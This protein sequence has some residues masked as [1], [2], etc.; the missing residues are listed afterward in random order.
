M[1]LSKLF[2]PASIAVVGAS[3]EDGKV[4]AVI[5]KNLLTL[6]FAGEVFLVNPKHKM[7]FGQ[8]CYASLSDIGTSVDLAVLAI[9][10]KFVNDE[11]AKNATRIKNYVV[12]SAGFAE[13]GP[14]GKAR[15][16]ALAQIAT[17]N[18]LNILGPNCLGFIVPGMK[19][20]A[21]FAG[22]MP[23]DGNVSFVSQSGALAVALMDIAEKENIG[24]SNI[25]SVGNKMQL[26]ETELLEYL[27]K[28][29]N[30]KV[31]G[32]Y[33][34]SV[35]DGKRFKEVSQAV[36][37]RKPVIIL[38]A[39]KNAKTQK[40]ISSH[41]GALAGDDE[42][43]SAVFRKNGVMR[44]NNLEEFFNLFNL[45]RNCAAPEKKGVAVITN[46]GGVG[47]LAADAFS[48]NKIMLADISENIKNELRGFLPAESSVENPIDLL[49]DAQDDRYSKALKAVSKIEDVGSIICVLTPQDQTPAEKIAEAIIDFKKQDKKIIV[50]VFLGGIRVEAA[51]A[52]LKENGICNFSFPDQ[53]VQSLDRYFSWNEFRKRKIKASGQIINVKR[54]EKV[55]AVIGK[56]GREGRTALYFSESARVMEMYGINTPAYQEIFPADQPDGKKHPPLKIVGIN[57][58]VVL[59]VDSDKVLHKTDKQGLILDIENEKELRADIS[60]MRANFSGA[61]LLVQPMAA[62]GTE[63]IIG[64]K[65]DANF[66]PVVVYGLGG[67]YTEILHRVDYLVPPLSI[68]QIEDSLK[69]GKLGFL[70]AGARGQKEYDVAEL[71]R[72]LQGIILMSVE[73]PEIREFDINPLIVYN[74]GKKASAIDVKIII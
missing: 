30:T 42:V 26:D 52:K 73:I 46:A 5:V 36:S 66:G 32:M 40:A 57:F 38:K 17:E 69:N 41:T 37:S 49:G 9:P 18:G 8:K 25:V 13:T 54:K 51:V 12:I 55:L 72:V 20:N 22:G 61:R 58:P 2:K 70:F 7:I 24:F 50:T 59:K 60:K 33:L 62:R 48:G 56:A 67:I 1:D 10:A 44:A 19:L 15:E 27:A 53:A 21:S 39:G 6:G 3:E 71:A 16:E 45:I 65:R 34:E 28:D 47:V 63:L 68:A 11:I 4:G 43:I 74:D 64:I 35:K 31:V 14:A 29:E 23:K